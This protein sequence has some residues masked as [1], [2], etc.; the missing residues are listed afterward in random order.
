M[1]EVDVNDYY[2]ISKDDFQKINNFVKDGFFMAT[3]INNLV[4]TNELYHQAFD[5]GVKYA[6][7]KRTAYHEQDMEIEEAELIDIYYTE[8]M[9]LL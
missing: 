2:L 6:S 8:K 3:V 4:E 1:K 5:K 9:I 7:H